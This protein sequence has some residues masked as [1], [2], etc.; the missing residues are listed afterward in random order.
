[1][2]RGWSGN[3]FLEYL[4]SSPLSVNVNWRH[5]SSHKFRRRKKGKQTCEL[6]TLFSVIPD[7]KRRTIFARKGIRMAQSP[8]SS[9]VRA[10]QLELRKIQEEPV[11]GFRVQLA[12]D[13]NIF[14]W[15]VA[16]FG[17]PSTLYE[18]GYFKV[19]VVVWNLCAVNI[20][21]TEAT[22]VCALFSAIARLSIDLLCQRTVI[23]AS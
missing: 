1:M 11:E 2:D 4:L 12:N 3:L 17:P 7:W 19:R 22:R 21:N 9:A 8:T 20:I 10:L 13:D 14:E 18:G 23:S 6:F 16:I 15:E 5:K